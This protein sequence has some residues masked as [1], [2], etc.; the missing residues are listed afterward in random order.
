M[1]MERKVTHMKESNTFANPG[2]ERKTRTKSVNSFKLRFHSC[3]RPRNAGA[4]STTA[5]RRGFRPV[6]T[7]LFARA[8]AINTPKVPP[9]TTTSKS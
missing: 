4:R 2:Q 5:T 3:A 6:F 1:P 7:C 8:A 9:Q